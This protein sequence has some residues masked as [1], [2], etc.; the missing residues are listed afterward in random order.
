MTPRRQ[1]GS[2]REAAAVLVTVGTLIVAT[3]ALIVARGGA[4]APH[5]RAGLRAIDGGQFQASG[6]ANVPGSRQFLFVDDDHPR[7]VFLMEVDSDGLQVGAAI[8]LPLAAQVTDPEGMTWDGRHFYIVGSQS[9]MTGHD[10][11]GLVRFSYDPGARRLANVE[12]IR[13]LKAWLAALVPELHGADRELG[14]HVLNIEGLAW[15]FAGRRL[16]LG[17]RAPVLGESALIIP[18]QLADTTAAFSR[19]NLQLAGASIRIPLNG[20]GIRSIEFDE[21]SQRYLLITGAPLNAETRSFRVMAWPGDSSP[22]ILLMTYDRTLKPEGVTPASIG[23]RRVSL[24]VFDTGR[25]AV[26]E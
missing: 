2:S 12:S 3:A 1:R 19:E 4:A 18:V 11:A 21:T 9:K 7:D 20:D 26:V 5:V 13:N 17:L 16:L 14:D 10:G 8:A 25:M 24:L 15:D 22:P 23:G 6:V